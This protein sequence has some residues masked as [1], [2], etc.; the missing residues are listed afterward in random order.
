M[1][2]HHQH[3]LSLAKKLPSQTLPPILQE[4]ISEI[5]IS[6]IIQI[7]PGLVL[8]SKPLNRD[9]Y[10]TWKMAMTLALNSKNK[11]DFVNGSIKAPSEE[12]DPE[13]YA[14]WSQC[15]DM[16]HSWIV[17]SLSPEISDSV[18]YYSTA[19]EVWKDLSTAMH[20]A[21]FIFS[22]AAECA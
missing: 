11:L 1:M 2:K 21:S 20:L 22:S 16:V 12:T 14:A 9:N 10:S 6:L 4:Q 7:H 18:I 19:H 17:N 5:P 13:G 15:N 8:I 3:L